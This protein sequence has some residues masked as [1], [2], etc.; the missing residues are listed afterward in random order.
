M[1]VAILYA[2]T[3]A[4]L[5]VIG[6]HALILRAHLLRKI[7]GFNVMGSGVFL[8]LAALARRTPSGI[9]DPVPQAMVIT[10]IVVAIA[11]TALALSLMLRV[12]AVTGRAE[13]GAAGA[14]HEDG[15]TEQGERP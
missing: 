5:F 6:L 13:L 2:L 9:P 3:G 10:G 1:S 11:A 8:V 7:L 14:C 15:D 12:A 4:G